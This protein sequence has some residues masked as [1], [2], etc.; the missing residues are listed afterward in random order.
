MLFFTF[1]SVSFNSAVAQGLD[2]P[3]DLEVEATALNGGCFATVELIATEVLTCANPN[4]MN[5][6]PFAA[7]NNS[8]DASGD[9][10]VGVTTVN[11]STCD[12]ANTCSVTVT[13]TSPAPVCAVKD[14]VLHLDAMGV[15]SLTANDVDD[16][17]S[18]ACMNALTFALSPSTFTCDDIGDVVAQF[19]AT[20]TDGQMC[21]AEVTVT[22]VDTFPPVFNPAMP[23]V[24]VD[25]MGTVTVDSSDVDAGSTDNCGPY[26]LTLA[27]NVLDC[28][29]IVAGADVM[30]TLEDN[31]GNTTEELVSVTV[32][33]TFPPLPTMLTS[34]FVQLPPET[35]DTAF[36]FDYPEITDNCDLAPVATPATGSPVSGDV[37]TIGVTEVSFVATDEYGN[38]ATY[39]FDI[40]VEEFQAGALTCLTNINLSIDSETCVSSLTP[41]MVLT[42]DMIGCPDSCTITI[43]DENENILPNVFTN[44]DV[45]LSY[46][47]QVCCGDNCCMGTVF[48]EDKTPPQ[49]VCTSDTI[50][51]G[52]FLNFPFPDV[53]ENCTNV[54]FTLLN[55]TIEEV[56]CDDPELQQIIT[57]EFQATD[58][59]G[60][61]SNVCSQQLAIRKFDIGTIE[62]P[63]NQLI[64]LE[65]GS[66]YPMDDQG[67]PNV[68]FYGGPTLNGQQIAIDQA[69]VCN[70]YVGFED[71]VITTGFNSFSIVR[72]F[73]ATVWYCGQDTSAQYV[74]VFEVGDNLG[75]IITCSPDLTFSADIFD[76]GS[77]IELPA[78]NIEDICG[79]VKT[80]SVQ[81]EGGFID[82]NGGIADLPLGTSTVT[83]TALDTENNSSTCSFEVTVLDDVQPVPVCDQFTTVSLTNEGS[84]IV[85]AEEFDDGSFDACGPITFSVRRM[86]PSC[87][88]SDNVLGESIT[89]CCEDLGEEHMVVLRV[90][91][92]NGNFNEC[93]VTAEVQDKT[94]PI[95][96]QGLPDIT[97]SCDFPFNQD[98]TEQFGTIQTSIDAVEEIILTSDIVEF[99][100]PAFDGLVLGGCLELM[101]D[102]FS[103]ENVNSCGI[104]TVTRIITYSNAQGLTVSDVQFITFENPDPFDINDVAFP[105][106]ITLF[107]VC[108]LENIPVTMPVFTEDVCDQIGIDVEDKIVDNSNGGQACFKIFRTFTIVDWCQNIN[109]TFDLIEGTQVIEVNNII[110]PEITEGCESVSICSY[111]NECGDAFI[112]LGIDATDDCTPA[113]FITFSY[114]IDAFSDGTI[115][116]TGSSKDASGEYPVGLHTIYWSVHD[117]CGNEDVCSYTFEIE[118]CKVPTPYC[119]DN[120]TAG[121]TPM[122]LD[123]DG[124]VDTE[125]IMIT[126]DF[127]DAGSFHVCGTPVQLSFSENVNDTERVFGCEDLGEQP[128]ELWVTDE[129]GNQDFCVTSVV[130]QDNN[131]VDFCTEMLL[132]DITGTVKKE[133]NEDLVDVEVS[134]GVP[135]LLEF[136]NEDGYYSFPQMP[137]GN[138]YMVSV[139]NDFNPTN[140]ITVADIILI[141]KHILGLDPLTSPYKLIAADVDNSQKI[142]GQDILQIRKLL[143]GHYDNFPMNESWKFIN[144]DQ[145]FIDPSNPWFDDINEELYIPNLNQNIIADFIGVKVGDV[146]ESASNDVTGGSIDTRNNVYYT[147]SIDAIDMEAGQVMDVILKHDL[148][149]SIEGLQLGFEYDADV[150]DVLDLIIDGS[151]ATDAQFKKMDDGIRI[152]LTDQELQQSIALRVK[153][154]RATSKTTI[155]LNDAVFMNLAYAQKEGEMK[156]S[157]LEQ[158]E[159]VIQNVDFELAQNEPN[160]WMNRTTITFNSPVESA[161]V[162]R[163]MDTNGKVVLSKSVQCTVGTNTLTI[164]HE[165]MPLSGIYYYEVKI[166]DTRQMRKMILIK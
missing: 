106:D 125:M 156:V 10:P 98:D 158:V 78:L 16:G 24:Y 18:E 27:D 128:I 32:L 115:D 83:Y 116:I 150:V 48:V 157:L 86:N 68:A 147:L 23:I 132:F 61:V 13:V 31:F 28:S 46:M 138:E 70:L 113:E 17:S 155:E 97:V 81:Y 84:A 107:N 96:V 1:L 45:G 129:N 126:P 151:P 77:S 76:C 162:F 121:L 87:D 43:M 8:L 92:E 22:V 71:Q 73:E 67:R 148:E 85:Y 26:T 165:E 145:V 133:N 7:D 153:A 55:E 75:P 142:N 110:A 63:V 39:S 105:Q 143:L 29:A 93:M 44:A 9:Y 30:V 89:F 119:L 127:F 88:L 166:G 94:A 52:D 12:G 72:T 34:I 111:D 90:T 6:S 54:T 144:A 58:D 117:E 112:E 3:A 99:S 102:E 101:S 11:F 62:P 19:T 79:S 130:I 122:D 152:L 103:F 2:C 5:D 108:D 59:A 159:D 149:Q 50:T 15:A 140:G 114:M 154:K 66:T 120:L 57:R 163:V 80:V 64:Q 56:D 146:N 134:L 123:G 161:G 109:G 53:T 139:T 20:D 49:I 21:V 14:T 33:D 124:E 47:Y 91:D 131:D 82:G 38:E 69:L 164:G 60:N 65:C 51:C 160:P 104:G 95:L 118:N 74:Q 137:L 36:V 40:I 141:Q 136:T 100:G 35:C 4:P 37:F 25:E 41:A 42:T 135:E